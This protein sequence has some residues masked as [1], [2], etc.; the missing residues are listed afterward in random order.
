MAEAERAPAE[1]GALAAACARLQAL[2]AA[3]RPPAEALRAA[4]APPLGSK[5]VFRFGVRVF[6]SAICHYLQ[7]GCCCQHMRLGQERG[8]WRVPCKALAGSRKRTARLTKCVS[9][10]YTALLQPG[11]HVHLAGRAWARQVAL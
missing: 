11:A 2:V 6:G 8:S 9:V 10:L 7:T 3:A 5:A 4:C 1:G